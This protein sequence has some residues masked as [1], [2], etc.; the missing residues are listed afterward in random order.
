MLQFI[1]CVILTFK[2]GSKWVKDVD[3]NRLG[4]VALDDYVWMMFCTF[5]GLSFGDLHPMYT[6]DIIIIC[7]VAF[8]GYFFVV[9]L[10]SQAVLSQL[11]GEEAPTLFSTPKRMVKVAWPSFVLVQVLILLFSAFINIADRKEEANDDNFGKTLYMTWVVFHRCPF[12]DLIP[13]TAG[14]K[15]LVGILDIVS[16]IYQPYII[17]LVAHDKPSEDVIE[18]A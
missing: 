4:E 6:F 12:G 7:F 18:R 11:G 13:E 17:A 2:S 10:Y 14:A 1:L 9:L 15:F 16:I 3:D 5:H 8:I